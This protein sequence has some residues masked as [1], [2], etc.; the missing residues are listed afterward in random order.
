MSVVKELVYNN[1]IQTNWLSIDRRKVD[2][3]E[4]RFRGDCV[5]LELD[6]FLQ[7]RNLSMEE[8]KEKGFCIIFKP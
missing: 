6:T 5:R 7:N 4:L 2:S 1:L 3:Y 8:N